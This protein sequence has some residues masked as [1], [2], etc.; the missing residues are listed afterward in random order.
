MSGTL[1]IP[2]SAA[3]V[4]AWCERMQSERLNDSGREA[5][6]LAAYALI[7][8]FAAV[9]QTHET[10][11]DLRA[12]R[13]TLPD[14]DYKGHS[15]LSLALASLPN[16]SDVTSKA[17]PAIEKQVRVA[18]QADKGEVDRSLVELR[19]Y[20]E[21]AEAMA[22][23]FGPQPSDHEGQGDKEGQGSP[24]DPLAEALDMLGAELAPDAPQAQ[25][26]PPRKRRRKGKPSRRP[27]VRVKPRGEA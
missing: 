13:A 7:Q 21:R 19:A 11:E 10:R 2:T 1:P 26:K 20:A 18:L 5:I 15:R 3:D 14:E 6:G 27:A 8:M 22:E 16:P 24:G 9:D 12:A 23:A 17:L 25:H 4:P